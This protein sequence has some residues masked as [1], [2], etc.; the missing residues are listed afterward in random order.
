MKAEPESS[1]T[2]RAGKKG[3]GLR[4]AC[5]I[6]RRVDG[7]GHFGINLPGGTQKRKRIVFVTQYLNDAPIGVGVLV[8]NNGI[9]KNHV[10]GSNH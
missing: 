7:A 5:P 6:N 2:A 3:I 4:F 8:G 9:F 10:Q 1:C